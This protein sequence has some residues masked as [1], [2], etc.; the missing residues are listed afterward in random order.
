MITFGEAGDST[1]WT[2]V[3]VSLE[4]LAPGGIV[5]SAFRAGAQLVFTLSRKRQ[6]GR[7][8]TPHFAPLLG[9]STT[10]YTATERE[11]DRR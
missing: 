8:V 1:I 10:C 5:L 2:I 6:C 7:R 4:E 11:R 9:Y 3:T